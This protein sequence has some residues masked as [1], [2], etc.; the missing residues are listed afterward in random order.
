[1]GKKGDETMKRGENMAGKATRKSGRASR[2]AWEVAEHDDTRGRPDARACFLLDPC[3]V[4][5]EDVAAVGAAHDELAPGAE[6]GHL[7][8][9]KQRKKKKKNTF[10]RSRLVSLVARTLALH[11]SEVV[12]AISQPPP[13]ELLLHRCT[14]AQ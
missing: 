3:L 8:F 1:M 5:E 12:Q 6:E 13:T 9:Q 10:R 7:D 11:T 2:E 4:P 14:W